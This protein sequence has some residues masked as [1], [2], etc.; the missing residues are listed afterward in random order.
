[1]T[2]R[3]IFFAFWLPLY[4]QSERGFS[5][6]KVAFIAVIPFVFADIGSLAGG[7]AGQRLIRGD[8]S[9]DRP[10]K[11]LIWVGAIGS[12]LA[13][14]VASVSSWPLALGLAAVA[15][16]FL[17]AK[18]ASLVPICADLSPALDVATVRGMTGAAGSFGAALFQWAIGHIVD[19]Y[20]YDIAFALASS[21]CLAQAALITLSIR[22]I[23][24]HLESQS[25]R[26][27][28]HV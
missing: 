12:L 9:V 10:R 8:W 28:P 25:A 6:L 15:I 16:V 20:G 13:W 17:Q 1:V 5:I 23:E 3:S 27:L 11:T 22:R 26:K 14:P 18:T 24:P 2:A 7:C 4:L 19:G 21:I